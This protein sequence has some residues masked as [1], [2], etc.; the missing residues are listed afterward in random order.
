MDA[1]CAFQPCAPRDRVAWLRKLPRRTS[2]EAGERRADA[3]HRVLPRLPR[4]R[5]DE[6]RRC[7]TG[8]KRLHDV[9]RL[10]RRR[11]GTLGA[12]RAVIAPG[13]RAVGWAALLAL[14]ACGG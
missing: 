9:P 14:A 1:R 3:E 6:P 10:S 12:A 4:R 8:A 11:A 5:R 2:F 13:L 7:R